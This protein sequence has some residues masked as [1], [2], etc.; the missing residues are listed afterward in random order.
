MNGRGVLTYLL[1]GD[2]VRH[3]L[4]KDLGFSDEELNEAVNSIKKQSFSNT[5]LTMAK[6]IVRSK[7]CFT[8]LQ[9]KQIVDIF[10]FES[11]KLEMAKFCYSYCVDKDNYYKIN[12]SFSFSSSVDDLDKYISSQH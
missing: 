9:I 2:N 10:S 12:D 4:N 5:Q 3:G 8:A 11:S 6:Q 7:Q 1:D